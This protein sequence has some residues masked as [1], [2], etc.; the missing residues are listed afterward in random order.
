MKDA[1][2]SASFVMTTRS[3]RIESAAISISVVRFPCGRSNVWSASWP[4]SRNRRRAAGGAGHLPG[5]SCAPSPLGSVSDRL[6]ALDS[7]ELR[8]EGED[9]QQVVALKVLVVGEDLVGRHARTQQFEEHL[10]WVAQAADDRLAV[11][12]RWVNR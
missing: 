6:N 1:T 9:G 5:T 11:R 8:R 12:D 3:S 7:A 10:D 2:K 4:A